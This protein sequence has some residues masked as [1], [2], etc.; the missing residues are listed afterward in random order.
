M[1]GL[2]KFCTALLK[3]KLPTNMYHTSKITQYWYSK[4]LAPSVISAC[5]FLGMPEFL[6]W[7]F[8]VFRQNLVSRKLCDKEGKLIPEAHKIKELCSIQLER[9][10]RL[11]DY[12]TGV[13]DEAV[14]SFTNQPCLGGNKCSESR[15]FYAD[16][17]A[18]ED[19]VSCEVHRLGDEMACESRREGMCY[20][21][22]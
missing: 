6:P 4:L 11:D 9:L 20:E 3:E 22:R 1:Q 8:Y 17:F 13:W 18:L 16:A 21:C 10:D 7:A 14:E 15:K 19:D 12:A 5:V 2:D